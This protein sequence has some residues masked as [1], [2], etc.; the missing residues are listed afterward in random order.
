MELHERQVEGVT[1]IALK[2]DGVQ[3]GQYEPFQQL[4]RTR[5]AA[6]TQR[7][8]VN[9]AGCEWIDSAG[10]GELINALVHVMRQGG[11]LKL[12]A[13]PH[14]V[15]GLLTVTNLTQVFEL[16]DNEA[17]ALASFRP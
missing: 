7:F 17:A 1:V 2:L 8:V 9:L 6:G 3:R 14:K 10:L 5:L 15:K 4:V 16:F 12:A 11:Q 13:V